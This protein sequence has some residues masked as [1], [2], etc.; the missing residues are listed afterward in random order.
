[1]SGIKKILRN[2]AGRLLAGRTQG[3]VLRLIDLHT[4]SLP[5]DKGLSF[6]LRLDNALYDRQGGLAVELGGGMHLKR[7]YVG[8]HEFFA[9]RIS[10]GQRVLDVGCGPGGG[11]LPGGQGHRGQRGGH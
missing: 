5:P 6:L 1:M 9:Q 3:L 8:Y 4:E 11:G 7:R 2:L 10:E